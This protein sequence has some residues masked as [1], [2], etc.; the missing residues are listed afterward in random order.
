MNR[1][2]KGYFYDYYRV[3]YAPTLSAGFRGILCEAM[4]KQDDVRVVVKN[5]K[6][7]EYTQMWKLRYSCF[8]VVTIFSL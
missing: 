8:F 3:K 6:K 1:S 7:N 4:D 5:I 2:N